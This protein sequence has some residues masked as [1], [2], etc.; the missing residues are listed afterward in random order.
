MSIAT[1]ITRLQNDSAAIASAIAAKGVSVP[2]GAGY[3]DYASLIAQITGGGSGGRLPVGY[4]E[5]EYVQTDSTAWID[6]G[7]A[8]SASLDVSL[9]FSYHKYV[10]Y[11]AAF[12]NY[13]S[14]S[15]KANRAIIAGTSSLYVA[16][17]N[18]LATEVNNFIV[19]PVNTLEITSTQAVLNEITTAISSSSQSANTT[20]I[21]L[22]NRGISTAVSRDIGLR[23]YSFS[24]KNNGVNV[25]QYVPCSRDSD[26][27]IGFYDTV[28]GTFVGSSTQTSFVAGPEKTYGYS[29]I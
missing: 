6:T 15:Y 23:I 27:K 16:G 11:G 4:T 29:A 26:D 2:S 13:V 19:G 10:Q 8:G 9:K 18:N 25:I 1:E 22:G 28:S 5:L 14:E 3:D 7:V 20:N 17:G 12:G 21:C 24:I